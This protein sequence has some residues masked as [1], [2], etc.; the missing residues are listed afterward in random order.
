MYKIFQQKCIYLL[1]DKKQNDITKNV[2]YMPTQEVKKM[3]NT[4]LLNKKILESGL[5][6]EFIA[7]NLGI[8]RF[9]FNKK[10]KNEVEF[11]ATEINSLC[12]LLSIEKLE[13]KWDIFFCEHVDIMPTF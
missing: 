7:K 11:K 6:R 10:I 4:V 5:K 13:E 2:D 1:T 9:S 12:K 3:T 8:S